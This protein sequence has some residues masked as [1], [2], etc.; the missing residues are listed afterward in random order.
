MSRLRTTCEAL[1]LR[2]PDGGGAPRGHPWFSVRASLIHRGHR[3]SWVLCCC[4]RCGQMRFVL[5]PSTNSARQEICL[6]PTLTTAPGPPRWTECDPAEALGSVPPSHCT[7]DPADGPLSL[8]PVDCGHGR[9]FFL[10]GGHKLGVIFGYGLY[11]SRGGLK[12]AL[13]VINVISEWQW[14][15]SNGRL[16]R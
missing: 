14:R 6:F 7:E 12:P 8:F 4:G 16:S 5:E 13:A 1:G 2:I 10:P 3:N 11:D 15:E 9:C